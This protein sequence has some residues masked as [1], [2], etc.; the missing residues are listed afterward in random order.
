VIWW[1]K[2][3]FLNR[4]SHRIHPI[5]F[6]AAL[7]FSS[8]AFTLV[9]ATS[10]PTFELNP[11]EKRLYDKIIRYDY[12]LK[13][14][15]STPSSGKAAWLR[16]LGLSLEL[17]FSENTA[18]EPVLEAEHKQL[19]KVLKASNESH[20]VKQLLEAEMK[21]HLGLARIKLGKD[22][23]AAWQLRS[24]FLQLKTL[25]TSYPDFLPARKS[26]GLLQVALAATPVQYHWV[27]KLMGI[28]STTAE[29]L[30]N[31]ELAKKDVVFGTEASMIEA[32]VTAFLLDQPQHGIRLLR[33]QENDILGSYLRF[34][35]L[36]KAQKGEL[37]IQQFRSVDLSQYP[38]QAY[39]FYG[40][41]LLQKGLYP[42]AEVQFKKFIDSCNCI[43]LVKSAYFRLHQ[44]YRL[45]GDQ[46]KA[47][48]FR[49]MATE[50]GFTIAEADKNADK[51]IRQEPG[52]D[53]LLIARLAFDGGF[54]E[55]A[56]QALEQINPAGLKTQSE[57]TEYFYRYARVYHHKG[58][59]EKALE[60]YERA[61]ASGINQQGYMVA[62]SALKLGDL[63]REKGNRTKSKEMYELALSVKKHEYKNS[64]DSKAKVGL[65]LLGN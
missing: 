20:Q 56:F 36:L 26:M 49:I 55:R 4:V 64:I 25:L 5:F 30:Q 22:L 39:Y 54:S 10:P 7:F 61:I 43:N 57:K 47:E 19:V 24:A 45:Q 48:Q 11:S 13:D 50:K 16:H 15:P 12:F 42:E 41:A 53:R 6:S 31:L 21:I 23:P 32:M 28:Y 51:E 37:A 62:N 29:G 34:H 46:N 3:V 2:K 8:S 60:Y 38:P 17:V 1:L 14:L 58:A 52:D 35:L 59:S 9:E 18:L 63:W 27:L 40:L 44:I 33:E 65:G